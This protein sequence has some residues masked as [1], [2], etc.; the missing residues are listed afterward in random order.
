MF[1][2]MGPREGYSPVTNYPHKRP[3]QL[4]FRYRDALGM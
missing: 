2:V 1:A 4:A 3:I